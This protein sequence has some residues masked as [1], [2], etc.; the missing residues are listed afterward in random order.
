MN[1][2]IEVVDYKTKKVIHRMDVSSKS[3]RSVE[4]IEDGLNI[5]LNHDKYFSRVQESEEALPIGNIE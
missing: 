3:E 1:K 4:R 5:N 2:Y